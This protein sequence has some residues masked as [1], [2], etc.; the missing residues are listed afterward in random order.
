MTRL[1]RRHA[2][3]VD[4]SDATSFGDKPARDCRST[5]YVRRSTW[6]SVGRVIAFLVSNDAGL[7]TANRVHLR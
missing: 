7:I 1:D 5:E 2:A 4:A 6:K 3:P